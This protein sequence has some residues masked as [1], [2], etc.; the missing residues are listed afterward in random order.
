M[1]TKK[2]RIKIWDLKEFRKE[3]KRVE[4]FNSKFEIKTSNI[5]EGDKGY[6]KSFK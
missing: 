3:A 5:F 1:K 4:E 6:L 2:V